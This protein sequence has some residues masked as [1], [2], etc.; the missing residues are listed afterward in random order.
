MH[1]RPSDRTF[2]AMQA[3]S[4]LFIVNHFSF[5]SFARACDFCEYHLGESRLNFLLRVSR[6]VRFNF[7][8]MSEV[9]WARTHGVLNQ[10]SC[11]VVI[12]LMRPHRSLSS[13][14]HAA[15]AH[16]PLSVCPLIGHGV[17]GCPST[18]A[19]QHSIARFPGL[20]IALCL[21]SRFS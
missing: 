16:I 20:F 8:K 6:F 1:Y 9:N 14:P 2:H 10:P 11:Q 7:S 21:L 3:A 5:V 4:V 12:G 17:R 15:A 13:P 19:P 18:K